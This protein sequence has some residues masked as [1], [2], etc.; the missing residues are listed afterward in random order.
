MIFFCSTLTFNRSLHSNALMIIYKMIPDV[1]TLAKQVA[2]FRKHLHYFANHPCQTVCIISQT[3]VLFD[4]PPLPNSLH[5][6]ANIFIIWRTIFAKQFALFRKHLHHLANHPCQTVCI[7]SQTFA[8]FGE[9]SLC[10]QAPLRK[11]QLKPRQ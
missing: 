4:E 5:Y 2:L 7:I 3:F 1:T 6:F 10:K 9:P 8:L 11:S